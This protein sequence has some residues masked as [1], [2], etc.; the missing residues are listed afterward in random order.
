[1]STRSDT[2]FA[3]PTPIAVGEREVVLSRNDWDRIV[4]VLGTLESE[5]EDDIAA[6]AA[7]CA[8]D[9]VFAA[10]IENERGTPVEVTIPIDVLEAEL[11]GTHPIRAWREYRKWTQANLSALSGVGRDLIAQ[12][13]TRRKNGSVETL[14]RMARALQVPIEALIEGGDC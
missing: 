8:E 7:A 2:T 14:S 1:M 6:A 9:A 11:E 13:E 4:Q 3:L 10:R 5:D 12:I